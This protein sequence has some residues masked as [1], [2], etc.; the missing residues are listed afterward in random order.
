[1][2]RDKARW[3]Y[4]VTLNDGRR[5]NLI[6]SFADMYGIWCKQNK[7]VPVDKIELSQECSL[8]QI[9]CLVPTPYKLLEQLKTVEDELFANHYSNYNKKNTWSG[10]VLRGYGGKEDFIIKPSEMTNSLKKENK[11]K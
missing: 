5:D 9:N 7:F 2:R 8:Q 1:M 10:S 4:S 11:E 3:C 6:T